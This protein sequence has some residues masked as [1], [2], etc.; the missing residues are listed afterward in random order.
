MFAFNPTSVYLFD[1]KPGKSASALAIN[2]CAR[3]V[4]A[5]ITT[6]FSSCSLDLLGP[7]ILF[8]ILAAINFFNIFAVILVLIYGARWRVNVEHVSLT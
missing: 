6:L 1:S 7:G 4:V 3:F 2:N 8:S 5:A